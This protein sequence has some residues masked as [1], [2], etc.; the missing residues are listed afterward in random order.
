MGKPGTEHGALQTVLQGSYGD[1][2]LQGRNQ[3]SKLV[4]RRARFKPCIFVISRFIT[5]YPQPYWL[6]TT[7]IYHPPQFPWVRDPGAA[8]L[9]GSGSASIMRLASRCRPGLRSSEAWPG[10]GGPPPGWHSHQVAGTRPQFL[11]TWTSPQ[12][13]VS[14]LTTWRTSSP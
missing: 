14:I 11:T 9:G 8:E 1:P 12:G 13:C 6:K 3:G 7:N 10:L 2:V 4:S 5:Y